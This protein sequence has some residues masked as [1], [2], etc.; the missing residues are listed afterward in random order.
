MRGAFLAML[1]LVACSGTKPKAPVVVAELFDP[2]TC[3]RCHVDHYSDWAGSMHAYASKDPVFLAMNR[4]GQRETNGALGPF[5]VNCHA[6]MAVRS[7]TTKD[8]L[9]L[10]TLPASQQGVTCF[11]C[12]AIDDVKGAHDNPLHL[13]SDGVMRGSLP[14]PVATPEHASAYA[15]FLDRDRPESATACGACHDIVSP[16]GAAI[17]RT[18]AEWQGSVFSHAPGGTTCAQCHMP[19]SAELKPIAHLPGLPSRRLHSHRLAAVDVALTDFPDA[20]NQRK[21]V[22]A[23]LD[24]TLQSALCVENL[25][26][27]SRVQVILDNVAA[28]HAFPSGAS[29]DRRLWMEVTA[30]NGANV[31]FQSGNV[32]DVHSPTLNPDPNLW[33]LRDCMFDPAGA[34]V[35]MFW[36]AA[37]IDGNELP[38][39]ATFDPAD[40]RYYK[41]HTIKNFPSTGG[42]VSPIDRVTL[43]VRLQPMG[44][45]VIDDL[46][47]TGDLDPALRAA[48]PTF[49]VGEALEWTPATAKSVYLNRDTNEYVPCVTTTNLNVQADKVPAPTHARCSP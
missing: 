37:S 16:K 6:P 28:G 15:P 12:H 5:C 29:Q 4:R 19:Q 2:Q 46:I 18:F 20:A 44:L 7:G 11:F 45:D 14:D 40:P 36:N 39:Q 38:A 33:L 35:S 8:G 41:T 49:T 25:G 27:G 17:E 43:R 21:E 30:Y 48:V 32:P 3:A 47:A 26:G 1:V 34:P 42:I 13:A 22:Q 9:N 10:E 31:V 24:S 23:L